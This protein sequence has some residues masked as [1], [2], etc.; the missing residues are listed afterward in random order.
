M[1]NTYLHETESPLLRLDHNDLKMKVSEM[2]LLKTTDE[3]LTKMDE[4]VEWLWEGLTIDQDETGRIHTVVDHGHV[5]Q[6]TKE[7]LRRLVYGNREFLLSIHQTLRSLESIDEHFSD[8]QYRM[9]VFLSEWILMGVGVLTVDLEDYK[10][11]FED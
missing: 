6:L 10:D 11:R 2:S 7:R 1:I 3:T 8:L 4:V 5:Q 9:R